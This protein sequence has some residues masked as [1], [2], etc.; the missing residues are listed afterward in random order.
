MHEACRV[1]RLSFLLLVWICLPPAVQSAQVLAVSVLREQGRFVMHAE[2]LVQAPVAKVR[3]MLTDYTNLPRI[4]K[5]LKRVDILDRRQD[6]G[7]R[8]GVVSEFCL[9]AICLDFNWVQDVRILPNGDIAM[10]IVPGRGDFRQGSGCWRLLSDNGGTRLIFDV[11]LTP[12]FWV[13]PAFGS[14]LMRNR[15]F[16]EA[17]ETGRGLERNA[18]P[19]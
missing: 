5:A 11:D 3:A 13:P 9:L 10:A 12:G 7:V 2:T 18:S 19:N 14:W 6:G 17:F 4:N 1:R 8:M 15:L 16:D